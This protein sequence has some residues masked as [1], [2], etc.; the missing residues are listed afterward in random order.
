MLSKLLHCI[1]TSMLINFP[2]NVV[3]VVVQ[4]FRVEVAINF[5]MFVDVCHSILSMHLPFLVL[6]C[7]RLVSR[8]LNSLLSNES[9]RFLMYML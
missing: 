9:T 3:V 5:L 8:L 1:P 6:M 4:C 2:T 7:S